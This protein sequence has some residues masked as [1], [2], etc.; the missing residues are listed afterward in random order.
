MISCLL[1]LQAMIV[2]G[3]RVHVSNGENSLFV[4]LGAGNRYVCGA[5]L[6]VNK[7]WVALATDT[8]VEI[9]QVR[10]GL[11]ISLIY[12]YYFGASGMSTTPS[13]RGFQ[14]ALRLPKGC[15]S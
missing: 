14:S 10:S 9:S 1:L 3:G 13:P 8:S 4:D 12:V 2:V 5:P 6:S 11:D 7:A 15:A